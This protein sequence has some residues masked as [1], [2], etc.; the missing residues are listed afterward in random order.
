MN[1]RIFIFS[2][3]LSILPLMACLILFVTQWKCQRIRQWDR[4]IED[5]GYFSENKVVT[6]VWAIIFTMMVLPY[7]YFA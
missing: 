3:L 4:I 6:I 5:D 1:N 2:I 7:V